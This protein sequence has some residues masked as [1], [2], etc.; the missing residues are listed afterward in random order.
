MCFLV[1]ERLGFITVLYTKGSYLRNAIWRSSRTTTV[2]NR[3]KPLRDK[4]IINVP[5]Y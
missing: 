3:Y 5:V 2:C 1:L 4:G